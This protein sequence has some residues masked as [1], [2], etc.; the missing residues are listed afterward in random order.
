MYGSVTMAR[1]QTSA[2]M[3]WE[4]QYG[5]T[6]MCLPERALWRLNRNQSV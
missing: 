2:T 3:G 4:I 6:V 5:D 1:S